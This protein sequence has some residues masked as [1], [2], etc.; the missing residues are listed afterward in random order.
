[1]SLG[2]SS[3]IEDTEITLTFEETYLGGKMTCNGYGGGPDSGKYTATGDGTLTI[4]QLAVTVQLCSSPEGVMEQEKAYIVELWGHAARFFA[5]C[6]LG[7]RKPERQL[8]LAILCVALMEEIRMAR[9]HGEA[10]TSY[11]DRTP[12]LFPLPKPVSTAISLP[13]RALLKQDRPENGAQVLVVF[14]AYAAILVLLSL[15]FV[16][17]KWPSSMGWMEWPYSSWP[18]G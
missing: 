4:L 2:G 7:R 11:R 13:M 1:M 3:L 14:L 16:A 17:L 8:A 15:P 18:F 12:F 5:P 10:Y 9:A 6:G